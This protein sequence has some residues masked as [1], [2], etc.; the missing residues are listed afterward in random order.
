MSRKSPATL[1]AGAMELW[2][3]LRAIY[4]YV[5]QA[6]QPPPDLQA[7]TSTMCRELL[8]HIRVEIQFGSAAVVELPDGRRLA[9]D[10]IHHDD[11]RYVRLI[12]M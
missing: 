1:T 4:H 8:A 6:D 12:E 11:G 7:R 5:A 9:A 10:L 3:R 2:D